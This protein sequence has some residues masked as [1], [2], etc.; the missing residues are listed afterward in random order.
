MDIAQLDSLIERYNGNFSLLY[1]IIKE[2]VANYQPYELPFPEE[3]ICFEDN[4]FR[5]MKHMIENNIA[6]ETVVDIGCQLGFQSEIFIDKY[7]YVGIDAARATFFNEENKKASYKIEVFPQI[8]EE[9]SNKAVISSMSIGYFSLK[10]FSQED[11]AKKLGE[12]KWLYLV[13]TPQMNDLVKRYFK[14][15]EHVTSRTTSLWFYT[16]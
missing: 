8:S 12:A 14:K 5:I 4:Y 16:K 10:E 3:F 13:S 7:N 9:L 11:M 6:A 2:R 15:S 1:P